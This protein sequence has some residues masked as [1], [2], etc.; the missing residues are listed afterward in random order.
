MHNTPTSN[1]VL[2]WTITSAQTATQALSLLEIIRMYASGKG[3]RKASTQM[4]FHRPRSITVRSLSNF[5]VLRSRSA[6]LASSRPSHAWLSSIRCLP[7]KRFWQKPQSPTIGWAA[8]LQPTFEQRGLLDFLGAEVAAFGVAVP[9]VG[10]AVPEVMVE[11][12]AGSACCWSVAVMSLARSVEDS[13][14]V[15][16][17]PPR[18][19]ESSCNVEDGWR[20]SSETVE[21]GS[22]AWPACNNLASAGMLV[23]ADRNSRTLEIVLVGLTFSGIAVEHM[24]AQITVSH[25][26]WCFCLLLPPLILTRIWMASGGGELDLMEPDSADPDRERMTPGM[27]GGREVEMRVGGR[28]RWKV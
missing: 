10:V 16:A 6:C 7:Q 21:E 11:A 12:T 9:L 3:S 2:E 24:L 22:R 23:E 13:G 14:S 8:A 20:L 28:S 4:Y 17:V 18:K 27:G 1:A 19:G 15:G 5:A 25:R 26:A